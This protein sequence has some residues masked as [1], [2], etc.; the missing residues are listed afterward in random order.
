MVEEAERDLRRAK[1]WV[2]LLDLYYSKNLHR[3]AL[4][5]LGNFLKQDNHPIGGSSGAMTR[6]LKRMGS[7]HSELIL[8]FSEV[9]LKVDPDE[10][11]K[12]Y[13]PC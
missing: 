7:E 5:M 10:G 2:E 11:L 9:L 3:K 1:K 13:G 6:Y 12:V 8:E 4:T